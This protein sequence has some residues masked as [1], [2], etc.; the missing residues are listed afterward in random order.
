MSKLNEFL[1]LLAGRFNNAG[2]FRA[3]QESGQTFPYAEH[4]NTLC[5]DKIRD[6]PPDF[7]G[8]FMLEESYYTTNGKTHPSHHLF[9]FTEEP[10]GIRLT[11]YEAPEGYGKDDFTYANLREVDYASL[12]PSAK[13]TPALYTEK[14]GVWEG[15]SVSQFTPAL[16]F[17]LWE[18]FSSEGLEVSER[19]EMN[20]RPT[21]GYG[22]PILYKRLGCIC[23]VLF[24]QKAP[25]AALHSL[26]F[27]RG[28]RR[29]CALHLA[30]FGEYPSIFDF[31]DTP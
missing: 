11:S 20:G 10:E 17:T 6:L 4:V 8:A 24:Y 22:E 9:L 27:H 18:R 16:K 1:A 13:F 29:S 28:V 2:Q 26:A 3:K 14:D 12:K 23:A 15:G 5:N 25:S 31:S 21:F 19:M 7:A 30:L